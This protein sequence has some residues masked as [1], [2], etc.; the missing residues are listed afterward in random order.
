MEEAPKNDRSNL[1]NW[2]KRVQ[3]NSWEPEILLSVLL[4]P[5]R[6]VLELF[7][8][9]NDKKTAD[10]VGVPEGMILFLTC[11]MDRNYRKI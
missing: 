4:V 5:G 3:E 2:L 8:G 6:H 1:P 10:K 7:D 9:L 11:C